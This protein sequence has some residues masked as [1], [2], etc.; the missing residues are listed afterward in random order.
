MF[1]S[2]LAKEKK[3][4][5]KCLDGLRGIAA[6]LVMVLHF[7]YIL[8]ERSSNFLPLWLDW[9][10]GYG[11]IGLYIFFVLSGFVIAY[12][13]SHEKLSLAYLK[14]FFIKRSIRLDPPYWVAMVLFSIIILFGN[15][16]T[17]QNNVTFTPTDFFLNF[18]YLHMFFKVPP[19]LPV[20]WTLVYELQFYFFYILFLKLVQEIHSKLNLKPHLYSSSVSYLV[21]G[22]LFILSLCESSK[23]TMIFP[24]GFFLFFWHSFFIGCLTYWTL[25]EIVKPLT[26]YLAW[27][28]IAIFAFLG[29]GQDLWMGIPASMFIYFVGRRGHLYTLFQQNIFQYF[30]KISYSLYLTHWLTGFKFISLLSYLLGNNFNK[31]SPILIILLA[32]VIAVLFADLFFRLV[33]YPSLK[34]SK[35]IAIPKDEKALSFI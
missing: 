27:L 17:K 8:K 13:L 30:G 7:N 11:Y 18:F 34:L 16:V 9:L 2:Q 35:R 29:F 31:I 10:V 32:S 19:I 3:H 23:I 15:L 14:C 5:F 26:L 33:E 6:L 22:S 4:R 20:V 21:F 24:N 28:C 1:T 12:N 25:E